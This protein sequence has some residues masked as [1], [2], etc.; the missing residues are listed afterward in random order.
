MTKRTPFEAAAAL[1]RAEIQ[2][3]SRTTQ[4]RAE[5]TVL[6]AQDLIHGAVPDEPLR[7]AELAARAALAAPL[8]YRLGHEVQ[9]ALVAVA[10][11]ATPQGLRQLACACDAVLQDEDT[12][13]VSRI[14]HM[15]WR[16]HS[17]GILMLLGDRTGARMIAR[18]AYAMIE[19]DDHTS[20]GYYETWTTLVEALDV[21]A[22]GRGPEDQPDYAYKPV[23][24]QSARLIAQQHLAMLAEV[25]LLH[26]AATDMLVFEADPD[27][28]DMTDLE[29]PGPL[30]RAP[31]RPAPKASPKAI[32]PA[33]SEP[34]PEPGPALR[35]LV[36]GSLDH[37]KGGPLKDY[38]L[39]AT[40]PLRSVP[41]PD[42]AEVRE[43]LVEGM[44][45]AAS[46]IARILAPLAGRDRVVLG[47]YLFVGGQGTGKTEGAVAVAEALGLPTTVVPCGGL[48]DGMWGGTSRAYSTARM[49]GAGQQILTFG[50][51]TVATVHDEFDKCARSDH[52]GSHH[53]ALLGMLEPTRRHVYHDPGL[54]A[55]C[56]LSGVSFLA[57]AN[58]VEPL[59]GPL[60]D[61]FTVV[62]WP[63][64]RRQ[65]LP[66]VARGILRVL[67]REGG[68]DAA[69]LPD[70]D[71]SELRALD[72][73]RG[74]SMRPLRRAIERLVALRSD[75]RLAN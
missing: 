63:A 58:S 3:A 64:P 44:P 39:S 2:A 35:P 4:K 68:L 1:M 45:W 43:R 5:D 21:A 36:S 60:L 32:Q 62:Q 75:P 18:R 19:K 50:C 22:H 6:S 41:V 16:D 70:L 37:L 34:E 20:L 69:W 47:P 7:Q 38:R 42:L 61:R 66:V 17:A 12:V 67:R 13:P 59:K 55:A 65:D 29:R 49:N 46:G 56:D 24:R 8:P 71:P 48:G 28:V 25:V 11:D 57:T 26:E 51:M 40:Q 15:Q 33:G 14:M 23:R 72:G 53:S 73:W 31:L 52:N 10:A 9:D 54:E 27:V 74:G 30:R